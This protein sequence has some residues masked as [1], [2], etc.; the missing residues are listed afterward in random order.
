[1]FLE[2]VAENGRSLPKTVNSSNSRRQRCC[3]LISKLA[4]SVTWQS[5]FLIHI[6]TH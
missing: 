1:M 2:A 5:Y 6:T 4:Y 3:S